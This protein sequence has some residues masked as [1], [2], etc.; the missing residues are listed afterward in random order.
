[1]FRSPEIAKSTIWHSILL[2]A[3]NYIWW[4]KLSNFICLNIEIP[5]DF[6]FVIPLN[7]LWFV[8]VYVCVCARARARVCV[9]VDVCLCESV[10][11]SVY[12]CVGVGACVCGCMR[13]CVRMCVCTIC[14]CIESDA[15][16]AATSLTFNQN[17]T[18]THNV[19]YTLSF[20]YIVYIVEYHLSYK[21]SIWWY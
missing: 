6:L 21:L 7:W 15:S 14:Y 18:H 13:A 3:T 19:C 4:P 9:F 8:C 16:Y 5:K 10:C 11:V 17:W 12:L 20:R 2:V 1:M